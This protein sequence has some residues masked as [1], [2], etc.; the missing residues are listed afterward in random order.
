MG[1]ES[2]SRHALFQYNLPKKLRF[3]IILFVFLF[4]IAVLFASYFLFL[5]ESDIVIF[6]AIKAVTDH[7]KYHM[8]N[9]T[10][11][12]ILYASIIGGLFFVTIPMEA[13]FVG[14]LRNNTNPYL[15]I[16][17]YLTGFIISFTINY[18]LG[19]RLDALTKK[20]IS[21]KKFY[22]I[23]GV[24]N[25]RGAIAVFAFNALPF[26]PSQPLSAILGVFKYNRVKFYVYF[27]LGQLVKYS[28]ITIG[29]IYIFA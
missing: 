22:K 26:F 14:F 8:T 1:E 11:L 12:G 16:T 24:L 2:F 9:G 4:V 27:I 21:S 13:F 5:K 25:K 19:M 10:L 29:Y 7:I 6:N 28:L 18:F 15:L 17:L 20:I 23:K 3:A